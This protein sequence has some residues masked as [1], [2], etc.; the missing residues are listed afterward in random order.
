[1]SPPVPAR[2]ASNI[3]DNTPSKGVILNKNIRKDNTTTAVITNLEEKVIPDSF[4]QLLHLTSL[5][6]RFAIT[7]FFHLSGELQLLHFGIVTPSHFSIDEEIYYSQ[8]THQFADMC[9]A[10]SFSTI[11]FRLN[12]L[13]ILLF[14][15]SDI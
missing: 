7:S 13:S 8:Y 6:L 1:M 4:P 10:Q 9:I 14:H 15:V 2:K 3:V 12:K 11:P 5:Y